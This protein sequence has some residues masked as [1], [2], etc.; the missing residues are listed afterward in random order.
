MCFA[1]ST[2]L[3]SASYFRCVNVVVVVLGSCSFF[4]FIQFV[5]NFFPPL[6][7]SRVAPTAKRLAQGDAAVHTRTRLRTQLITHRHA[8]VILCLHECACVCD[9]VFC[10]QRV[11]LQ[12]S[13]VVGGNTL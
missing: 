9:F 13:S 7:A 1:C 10:A 4:N 11:I 2:H 12:V 5:I 8:Y 6:F 3:I